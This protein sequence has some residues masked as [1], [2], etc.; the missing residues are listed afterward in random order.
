MKRMGERKRP[1]APAGTAIPFTCPRAIFAAQR[2]AEREQ[3]A[4]QQAD[5]G[6]DAGRWVTTRVGATGYRADVTARTHAFVTDEPVPL[7]GTDAGPTP[8]EYLLSA[9]GGCMAITLRMY[10][11][12]KGWPLTG[13]EVRLRS[14]RAHETDCEGCEANEV[15]VGR[16]ERTIILEGP[17]DDAQRTRLLSIGDRCPVKQTLMKGIAI[18]DVAAD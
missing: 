14:G 15:D 3:M 12:R 9:L 16:V 4:E 13:I 6:T 1:A 8:Y 18:T 2:N 7:G 10:A 17:L 5:G 11:D